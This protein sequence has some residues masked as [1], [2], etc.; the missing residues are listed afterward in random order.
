[1]EEAAQSKQRTFCALCGKK[2]ISSFF[3]TKTLRLKDALRV[4]FVLLCAFVPLWLSL[5][6]FNHRG[7]G[8]TFVEECDA[9]AA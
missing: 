2:K 9:T 6:H 7:Y 8:G 4:F 5:K 3:A 1:M